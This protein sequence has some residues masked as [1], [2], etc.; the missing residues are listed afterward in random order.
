[1]INSGIEKWDA[2]EMA[3]KKEK[4]LREN[5]KSKNAGDTNEKADKSLYNKEY[6]KL[7][8]VETLTV[9]LVDGEKVRNKY[10]TD[11]MEGGHGYVYKWIP[12][13][14][15]WIEDG[16]KN[17]EIPFIVL[18]EFVE[19]TFMKKNKMKYDDAHDIASKVEW[20]IRPNNFT[21]KDIDKLTEEKLIEWG[22]KFKK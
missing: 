18:H 3:I 12:D 6:C 4:K 2:Y 7:K 8:D 11:F 5:Y 15:I 20:S 14:E 21:K 10:K 17:N 13:D 22:N 1:L 9:W 19:R 16:L